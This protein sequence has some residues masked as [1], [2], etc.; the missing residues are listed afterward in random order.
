MNYLPFV[1]RRNKYGWAPQ[2]INQKDYVKTAV[3]L[4]I[5]KDQYKNS[6]GAKKSDY[7]KEVALLRYNIQMMF[8]N[9]SVNYHARQ[10]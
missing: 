4:A 8:Y 1:T 10:Q 2:G 3:T 6:S 7:E 5:R 9:A